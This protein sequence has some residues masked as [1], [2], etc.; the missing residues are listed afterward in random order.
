METSGI[1][2][3]SSRPSPS[4]MAISTC[5]TPSVPSFVATTLRWQAGEID[6]GISGVFVDRR[7]HQIG[8]AR[9]RH[10][11]ENAAVAAGRDI[12]PRP[13]IDL[14]DLAR[15]EELLFLND[16]DARAVAALAVAPDLRLDVGDGID[17]I[18][19]AVGADL[20]LRPLRGVAG[21]RQLG[22]DQ[23]VEPIGAL[24]RSADCPASR[25]RRRIC[26][27]P[28]ISL[29][30]VGDLGQRRARRRFGEME[31]LVGEEVVPQPLRRRRALADVR[32][33]FEAASPLVKPPGGATR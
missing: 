15:G 14:G 21:D 10:L 24:P 6:V 7:V 25:S 29:H 28:R 4:L 32:A 31:R 2:A 23:Q 11:A 8:H 26:P 30:V 5:E 33:L 13:R 9:V 3:A 27:T 22:V 18:G 20:A 19:G 17:D 1:A 12:S 16:D